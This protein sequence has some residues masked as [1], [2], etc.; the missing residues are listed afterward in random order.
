MK[1]R[2]FN[3]LRFSR[4]ILVVRGIDAEKHGKETRDKKKKNWRPK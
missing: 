2:L 3:L 1:T 4:T